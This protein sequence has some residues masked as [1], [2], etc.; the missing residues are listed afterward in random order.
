MYYKSRF[1]LADL[2]LPQNQPFVFEQTAPQPMRME[3]VR[4]PA[5][6]EK[7]VKDE[8]CLCTI[9]SE[10]AVSNRIAAQFAEARRAELA[11]VPSKKPPFTPSPKPPEAVSQAYMQALG[12]MTDFVRRVA[13]LIRWRNGV[14][15]KHDPVVLSLGTKW[16]VDN[17]TWDILPG[18]VTLE[19]I[20]G[21]AYT[22]LNEEHATFV[23]QMIRNSQEQPFAHELLLEALDLQ[24]GNP[25][26]SLLIGIAAAELGVKDF[27]AKLIPDAEWLAFHVPSPPILSILR[28]YLPK[29]PTKTR[30]GTS[31]TVPP[32]IPQD[33]L[34]TLKKGVN[35]RNET[36]HAGRTIEGETLR[37]VLRAVHDLLY[38]LDVYS[39]HAWA[40]E[41]VSPEVTA[42]MKNTVAEAERKK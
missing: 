16:S 8:Q 6:Q 35:L 28:D 34:E 33:I 7:H 26:G 20:P 11:Y 25:R 5:G 36:A 40:Q 18:D 41:H 37:E 4:P 29:L 13:K 14:Q 19:I 17:Q 38:I 12:P 24:Y 2:G 21:Y 10:L 31:G 9:E 1:V 22:P 39:G 15:G 23:R 3:I 32:F 42:R 30:F 27:I